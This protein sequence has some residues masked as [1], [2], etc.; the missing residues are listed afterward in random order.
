M[1]QHDDLP[2]QVT[3][4]QGLS[5]GVLPYHVRDGDALLDLL[6]CLQP[7]LCAVTQ[8]TLPPI[9]GMREIGELGTPRVST[10]ARHGKWSPV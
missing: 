9:V 7:A 3:D 5:Q 8:R 1:I 10:M 2:L 4:A 6:E